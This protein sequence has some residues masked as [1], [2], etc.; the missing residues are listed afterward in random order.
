[1]QLIQFLVF[2]LVKNVKDFFGLLFEEQKDRYELTYN[3][4]FILV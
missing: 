4:K 1:M 3:V 2:V